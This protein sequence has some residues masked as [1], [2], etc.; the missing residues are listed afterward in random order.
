MR[1]M[2]SCSMASQHISHKNSIDKNHQKYFRNND[3]QNHFFFD[4]EVIVTKK[5]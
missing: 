2:G 4:Y 5:K 1:N 3:L